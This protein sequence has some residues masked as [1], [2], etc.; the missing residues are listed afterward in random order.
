VLAHVGAF[1]A[2]AVLLVVGMFSQW[3]VDKMGWGDHMRALDGGRVELFRWMYFFAAWPPLWVA[4]RLVN[5][6]L[7]VVIERTFF[8]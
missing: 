8:M 5:K 1:L 7:F 2:A 6:R 3:G 4:A